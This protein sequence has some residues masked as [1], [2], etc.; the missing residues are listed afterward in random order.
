MV[1]KPLVSSSSTASSDDHGD[2]P[3]SVE[4]TTTAA[5]P[6]P[7]PVS[8]ASVKD[9]E[10]KNERKQQEQEE[11]DGSSLG[12]SHRPDSG[13]QHR[14]NSAPKRSP[15]LNKDVMRPDS[16]KTPKTGVLGVGSKLLSRIRQTKR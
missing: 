13:L 7:P 1:E 10:D 15:S 8:A 11:E 12:S 14:V 5:A 3:V 2:Q 16:P 9:E 6:P 4:T